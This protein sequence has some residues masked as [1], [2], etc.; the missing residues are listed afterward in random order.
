MIDRIV[1]ATQDFIAQSIARDAHN[2][3]VVGALGKDKLDRNAR[4]GAADNRRERML[5]WRHTMFVKNSDI[6][7]V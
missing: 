6:A 3:K 5:R 7:R 4:V 2:E 1:E